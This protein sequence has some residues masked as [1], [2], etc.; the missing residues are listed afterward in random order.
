MDGEGGTDIPDSL[1]VPRR[2]TLVANTKHAA[3]RGPT[4]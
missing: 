1:C 3:A 4:V 2:L